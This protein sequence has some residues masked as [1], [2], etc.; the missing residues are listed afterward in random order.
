MTDA[1]TLNVLAQYME[2]NAAESSARGYFPQPPV[3]PF[4]PAFS[5]C[6]KCHTV[7]KVGKT[8]T[9]AVTTRQPSRSQADVR[10]ASE[11]ASQ[12]WISQ[13]S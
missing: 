6:K 1:R 11:C 5:R 8:R 9:K 2:K 7:L 12:W 3:L 10:Y 4:R 13:L